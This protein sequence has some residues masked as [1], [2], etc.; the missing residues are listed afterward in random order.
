MSILTS[1]VSTALLIIIITCLHKLNATAVLALWETSINWE[2]A[3]RSTFVYF[4]SLPACT[5]NTKCT[6]SPTLPCM[7]VC[8]HTN[9]LY[10]HVCTLCNLLI[11]SN[12]AHRGTRLLPEQL[13]LQMLLYILSLFLKYMH[14]LCEDTSYALC[15]NI[16]RQMLANAVVEGSLWMQ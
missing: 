14:R 9:I 10:A 13:I 2:K 8:R 15:L 4:P 7:H 16:F 12:T 3:Y 1:C 11:Q 5:Y 6:C